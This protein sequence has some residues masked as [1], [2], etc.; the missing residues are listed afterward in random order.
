[1]YRSKA[2]AFLCS[3]VAEVAPLV[4]R[5][6]ANRGQFHNDF[7]TLDIRRTAFGLLCMDLASIGSL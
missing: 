7:D 1:M 2:Y 4:N 3:G 5:A 6:R